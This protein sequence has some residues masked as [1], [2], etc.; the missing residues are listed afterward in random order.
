MLLKSEDG[1][2]RDWRG[3]L[4]LSGIE[5]IHHDEISKSDEKIHKIIQFWMIKFNE[6]GQS[7]D[8]DQFLKSLEMIDRNDVYDDIRECLGKLTY[9]LFIL[10]NL[11]IF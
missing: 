6:T 8:I 11:N 1:Y 7:I 10:Q 4:Q 2:F 9:S 5:K 3:L